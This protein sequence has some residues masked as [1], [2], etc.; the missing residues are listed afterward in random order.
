MQFVSKESDIEKTVE[1]ISANFPKAEKAAVVVFRPEVRNIRFIR[2][3]GNGSFCYL[4]LFLSLKVV[5]GWA[6]SP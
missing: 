2:P 5:F 1:R 4:L 6:I 3:I